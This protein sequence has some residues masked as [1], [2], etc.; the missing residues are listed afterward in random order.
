MDRERIL[1][2]YTLIDM[3]NTPDATANGVKGLWVW[4]P[5]QY[6]RRKTCSTYYQVLPSW[7]SGVKCPMTMVYGEAASEGKNFLKQIAFAAL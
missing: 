3:L 1:A 7:M 5:C 2:P 4:V 6:G